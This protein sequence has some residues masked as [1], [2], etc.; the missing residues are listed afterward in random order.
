MP[1]EPGI[2][3]TRI[4]ARKQMRRDEDIAAAI[5]A[6][7]GGNPEAAVLSMVRVN[8]T[9]MRELRGLIALRAQPR[10]ALRCH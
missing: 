6:R 2:S 7:C 5:I 1:D 4:D 9:L 3:A 8:H 10:A